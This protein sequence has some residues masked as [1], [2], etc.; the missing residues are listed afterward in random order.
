ATQPVAA[1]ATTVRGEGTGKPIA[2][3]GSAAGSRVSPSAGKL[4]VCSIESGTGPGGVSPR[5]IVCSICSPRVVVRA[6]GLFEVAA[7]G[8]AGEQH[9]AHALGFVG[10]ESLPDLDQSR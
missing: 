1:P 10:I 3:Q 2:G 9:P 4:A 8:R 5:C 6:S 7:R